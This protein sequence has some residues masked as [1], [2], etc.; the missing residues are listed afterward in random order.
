[1]NLK[2][3]ME[4]EREALKYAIPQL[5]EMQTDYFK[6]IEEL[7]EEIDELKNPITKSECGFKGC[8]CKA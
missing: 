4:K 1:M 8:K 3:Y 5:K 2:E 6:I 7:L